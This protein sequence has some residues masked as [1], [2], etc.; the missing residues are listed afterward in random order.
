MSKFENRELK[1]KPAA[2]GK[3]MNDQMQGFF[4]RLQD[5][6][7]YKSSDWLGVALI[8]NVFSAS[9]LYGLQK[10]IF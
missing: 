7:K 3:V 8:L 9:L 5:K 6:D 4:N 2:I 10:I 1:G